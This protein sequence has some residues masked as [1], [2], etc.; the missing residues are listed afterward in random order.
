MQPTTRFL[1]CLFLRMRKTSEVLQVILFHCISLYTS[2]SNTN[3]KY[4]TE[5]HMQNSKKL[6]TVRWARDEMI[7][8]QWLP[9]AIE[10]GLSHT[11]MLSSK[12]ND[13]RHWY[14]S[15]NVFLIQYETQS[16]FEA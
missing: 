1:L 7:M 15:L 13:N 8:F 14:Y 2:A 12:N 4:A 3:L 9:L 11:S 5:K 10:G 6:F 16:A